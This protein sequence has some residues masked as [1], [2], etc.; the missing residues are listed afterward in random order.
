MG[1]LF[2]A[3]CVL[4]PSPAEAECKQWDASGQWKLQQGDLVVIVNLRQS[5]TDLSGTAQYTNIKKR[6]L[7]GSVAGTV[8]GSNITLDMDWEDGS[9]GTY[10]GVIGG[11]GMIRGRVNVDK[12]NPSNMWDWH[13]IQAMKCAD[14]KPVTKAPPVQLSA[15]TLSADPLV[16]EIPDGQKKGTTTLTWDSGGRR[17][18]QL[19]MNMNNTGEKTLPVTP[20]GSVQIPLVPGN[21][22]FTL[23]EGGKWLRKVTVTAKAPANAPP[24]SASSTTGAKITASPS[25][26]TIPAGQ[27]T[28]TTTLTWDAGPKHPYAE[29]WVTVDGGDEKKIV[30]QG[31]GSR[32]VQVRAGK[33]YRYILTDSGQELAT[34]TVKGK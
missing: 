33:I 8:D 4:L 27:T 34:T 26:V 20:N 32:Q 24:A 31:K 5:G 6:T 11:T 18:V 22:V 17:D 29:V 3:V 10:K 14:A 15:A 1:S 30:E 21:T 23:S 2:F 25:V 9:G 19:S 7:S 12:R 16:V 28:G 13:S